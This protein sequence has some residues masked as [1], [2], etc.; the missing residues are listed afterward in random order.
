MK[1][2]L[3][4]T[5]SGTASAALQK[6][7]E[8]CAACRSQNIPEEIRC[9]FCGTWLFDLGRCGLC[10][11]IVATRDKRC[12]SCGTSFDRLSPKPNIPPPAPTSRPPLWAVILFLTLA[13]AAALIPNAL[14]TQDFSGIVLALLGGAMFAMF[15][16]LGAHGEDVMD[17][18]FLRFR[19]TRKFLMR[20]LCLVV[21][22]TVFVVTG[23]LVPSTAPVLAS[24]YSQATG[25]HKTC[26]VV[27]TKGHSP[28]KCP[29][30]PTTVT[31]HT[32]NGVIPAGFMAVD[33][34]GDVYVNSDPYPLVKV[35]PTGQVLA[36]WDG[37]GF[38]Q[39]QPD[40]AGG[41]AVDGQGNVY[42]ADI[43]AD[44]IVKLSPALQVLAQWGSYGVAPGQ[45]V[46]PAGVALDA[47]GNIYVV[48]SGNVRIQKLSP[49]GQ[50]LAVWNDS[51]GF[52]NP[53]G[54]A[55][56]GQNNVYVADSGNQRIV[57]LSTTGEQVA[58]WTN[59]PFNTF[60][61]P[62]DV[63]I[64]THG[65]VYVADVGSQKVV[66][67]SPVGKQLDYWSPDANRIL[68]VIGL[69]RDPKQVLYMSECPIVPDPQYALL[70]RMA[71]VSA[72]GKPLVIWKAG[73]KASPP[74]GTKVDVGGYSLYIHCSGQGSPTVILDAGYGGTSGNW[75]YIQPKIA[76]STR[77]CSYDR[78]GLG[79]SDPRPS[80]I[81]G[82]GTQI[83]KE[84]NT[85]LLKAH[86]DGPYIL[87]GHSMGGMELRLYAYTYPHDVAGM[88]LV[89]SSHE[90]QCQR[91][92]DFCFGNDSAEDVDVTALMSQL[93]TA[94]HGGV[95]GSLGSIPLAVLTR[96]E[97]PNPCDAQCATDAQVWHDLQNELA[98]ASTNSVHVIARRSGHFIHGDQPALVLAAISQ[99][100]DAAKHPPHALA[101]CD[102]SWNAFDGTC[103]S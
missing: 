45:F 59:G 38:S 98:T 80:G 14:A 82:D 8:L 92:I 6:A 96:G 37:L 42:V 41:V 21:V 13:I 102:S 55:L 88:V 64:D 25:G 17:R 18:V 67:L 63:T 51:G 33:S 60:V 32:V 10:D 40:Y 26:K 35:S 7:A 77:V 69:A 31:T 70:C 89:D 27:V 65:S 49:T 20:R 9:R 100:V 39:N 71:K 46:A 50:V 93:Q 85:L 101:A 78:A 1:R 11:E 57:K 22:T 73:A 29:K 90:D 54:I 16:A 19:P 36:H 34:Q 84:L 15:A 95:K 3:T 5:S 24:S 66:K 103:A 53:N 28:K 87:I 43:N 94:R 99:V 75:G 62:L 48:D 56:D 97:T 61:Y 30:P 79:Y 47:Q 83:V 58:A 2:K 74:P 81:Q 52:R 72:A 4:T 68:T 12:V 23:G 86:I 76:Q 44:Q 91:N